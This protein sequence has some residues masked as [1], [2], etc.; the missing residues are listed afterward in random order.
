MK[1]LQT[2]K[3]PRRPE[4]GGVAV[5]EFARDVPFEVRRVY[6]IYGVKLGEIRGYHAHKELSQL[7]VCVVGAIKVDLDDGRDKREYVLDD[8][9]CGL[10]VGPSLWR[11]MEW[12]R[13]DSVL[14]VLAS[15]N[16]D[17]RDY[18]RDYDSFLSWTQG[19]KSGGR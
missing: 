1:C 3:D 9:S 4:L 8:P 7:L 18:I 19:K 10:F 15:M 16:Y 17:E 6:Y 5:V 12:L 14:L 11:T 13:D 2:I